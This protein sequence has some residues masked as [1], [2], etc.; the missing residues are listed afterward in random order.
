[1]EAAELL[2]SDQSWCSGPRAARTLLP[3]AQ[4]TDTVT[5]GQV[6]CPQEQFPMFGKILLTMSFRMFL[7]KNLLLQYLISF[8]NQQNNKDNNSKIRS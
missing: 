3:A 1:M 2:P 8:I 5:Q 4:S 7:A 6:Q